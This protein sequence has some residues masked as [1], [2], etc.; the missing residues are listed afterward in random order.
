LIGSDKG[1]TGNLEPKRNE[2][3]ARLQKYHEIKGY[4]LTV[5]FDGWRSGWG[6]ESEQK[7]GGIQIIFSRLGE[8]ADEV[9]KRLAKE[10][11]SG[12][13]VV[14]SDRELRNWVE[15][16]GA[17][18]ISAGEFMARLANLDRE[19]F[20]DEPEESGARDRAKKGNPRR[21]SKMERRR[22]ERL[23]KL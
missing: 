22:K 1:L 11:G 17:V 8:K 7:S 3:I 21:L 10:L 6:R 20:D 5:V 2:L 16:H 15:A 14:T 13:V 18:S 19:V 4:P 12:C 9:I 23:K